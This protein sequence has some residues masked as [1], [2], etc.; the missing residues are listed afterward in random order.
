MRELGGISVDEGLDE[1]FSD[2]IEMT[3][4]CRFSNCSHT[5]EKGCAILSAIEAD[6]LFG[7][8]YQSYLKMKKESDFNEM[9]YLEKKTKDKKF[10]K[11]IK[12]VIKNKQR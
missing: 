8:R 12:S 11:M 3:K 7:P 5:N 1:T 9:S 2:I 10:G 6:D 4:Q